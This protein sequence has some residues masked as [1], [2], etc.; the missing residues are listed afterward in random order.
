MRKLVT[1]CS[2][3]LAGIFSACS[4]TSG[5]P[6]G[7]VLYTGIDKISIEHED[8]SEHAIVAKEE[9][10]ATLECPPN[11]SF[12]GSSSLKSP[13]PIGL[14]VYNA[15]VNEQ[16][17]LGKWLFNTFGSTPVVISSVN[18]TL[19]AKMAS[20]SLNNF[21]YF[22]SSVTSEVLPDK[23]SDKKA[24]V[25]YKVKMY[26]P[27]RLDSVTYV[28]FPDSIRMLVEQHV[29]DS[30]L[31]KGD[32]FSVLNLDA[33]RI[34]LAELF[35]N[36]GY[37]YYKPDYMTYK[38]DT[39]AHPWHVQLRMEPVAKANIPDRALHTWDIGSVKIN[40]HKN[41]FA[42]LTDSLE[43]RRYTA[44]YT[45][46]KIPVRSGP[47]YHAIRV[48]PKEK[49]SLDLAR[50]T[51]DRLSQLGVF[52]SLELKYAP[53]DTTSACRTLDVLID[54]YLDKP[55]SAELE[56]NMRTKSNGQMGPSLNL[57][58]SRKNIFRGGETFSVAANGSYEWQTQRSLGEKASKVNSYEVGLTAS[59]E[60]PRLMFPG[61]TKSRS[62][63]QRSTIF[64]LGVN[65]LHR[66]GYF[67]ILSF[68]GEAT[69]NWQSTRTD[70]LSFSPLRL[71]YS[72][73]QN[74]T[75][76]FDSIMREN[77]F[78]YLSMNDQ[79]I[80]AMSISY[81]HDDK[82]L[83]KRV[84]TWWQTTFTE[85]GNFV[86]GIYALA[87]KDWNEKNKKLLNNPF[88][89]FVKLT[90]ELHKTWRIGDKSQLATRVMSGAIWTYGNSKVAPYSEQFYSGGAN[91]IRAYTVR[92]IGPGGYHKEGA[93]YMDQTGDFKF[94]ANAEYRFNMVGSFNGAF[95]LD[96]GNVWLLHKDEERP[97]AE[98]NLKRCWNQIAVGT[99]FGLR[100]DME[101]LVLRLDLGIA[102]HN[103]Y[104]TEKK[105]YYNIPN[106][107]DGLSLHFAIGY[108][109]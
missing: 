76:K 88:A 8:K 31:R 55:L 53:S 19:R 75:A 97:N 82:V 9:L 47:L 49:Y 86:S 27:Y 100:Y 17:G 59:L 61:Q 40:M 44:Y 106:F 95:F 18:P 84:H 50:E 98:F 101:F 93:T 96:A 66:A 23:K 51:Q 56:A 64:K 68:T 35:Q 21:G 72:K 13:L 34:R 24:K 52:S 26:D 71:T 89:Q 38:A 69:Y 4:T 48:K 105:G 5:L 45:G 63:H 67:D 7:E 92:G 37:F 1:I 6:S 99:G 3:L 28:N 80:P 65:E 36:A 41:N 74:Y 91:S 73:L 2:V 81:T 46:P 103:P 85:S 14:W 107:K 62:R 20:I 94:E 78:L 12:M 108:P 42:A 25:A 102:L 60:F 77:T 30:H 57:S 16:E 33:E 87:G 83:Q 79:F 58:V 90:A 54:A 10:F 39:V 109:F 43:N 104:K 15:F 29:T 32:A 22:R 70:R 11:G